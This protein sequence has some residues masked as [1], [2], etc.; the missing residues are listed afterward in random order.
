[1]K[2]NQHCTFSLSV[3]NLE[4]SGLNVYKGS[5]TEAYENWSVVA[6]TAEKNVATVDRLSRLL[7]PCFCANRMVGTPVEIVLGKQFIS[8]ECR[9]DI[10]ISINIDNDCVIESMWSPISEDKS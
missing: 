7:A 8:H 10:P 4:W 2:I 3:K 9:V 6:V 1:M 5:P